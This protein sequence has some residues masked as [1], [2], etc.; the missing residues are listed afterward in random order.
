MRRQVFVDARGWKLQV[1][2]GGE[3]DRGDDERALYFLMLDEQ[4]GVQSSVRAR[5][6]EDWSMLLDEMPECLMGGAQDLRRPGVWEMARYL[7][8]GAGRSSDEARRRGPEIRVGLLEAALAR[9]VSEII[10]VLD[11]PLYGHLHTVGFTERPLGLATPYGQGTAIAY[12]VEVSPAAVQH[13]R[14]K[15]GLSAPVLI[16]INPGDP[17]AGLPLSEV[18]EAYES[19]ARCGAD[20]AKAFAAARDEALRE[21]TIHHIERVREHW[22]EMHARLWRRVG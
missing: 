19:A 21:L 22:D 17:W 16:E 9:G 20:H 12:A 2:D 6:V 8:A 15:A 5:P 18:E 1:R 14:R 11:S 10:G 7:S 4:G 3:Y 13:M